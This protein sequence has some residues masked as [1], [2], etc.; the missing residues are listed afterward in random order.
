[1]T[2]RAVALLDLHRRILAGERTASAKLFTTIHRPIVGVLLRSYGR[3]GLSPEDA[4]NL[5]TDALMAYVQCPERFE[6][7]RSSLFTYLCVIARG[8]ALNLIEVHRREQ[9]K[10]RRVVEFVR[11]QGNITEMDTRTLDADAL[12]TRYAAELCEDKQDVLVLELMLTGEKD[13]E[14]YAVAL[15][16]EGAS[17]DEK[18]S[19]VKQRRDRLEKRLRRLGA[20][21]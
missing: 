21:L 18:A 11:D 4:S 14:A 17:P 2:D 12:L 7:N 10:M 3:I 8:D 13:T 5:A 15:G 20:H 9:K 6:P 1:M 19:A 16:L